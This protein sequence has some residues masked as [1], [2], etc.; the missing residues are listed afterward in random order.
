MKLHKAIRANDPIGR[1]DM[2]HPVLWCSASIVKVEPKSKHAEGYEKKDY[3]VKN[4]VH[5]RS[6]FGC[7]TQESFIGSASCRVVGAHICLKT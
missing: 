5:C 3:L 4:Y 6:P 2:P 7:I 1:G